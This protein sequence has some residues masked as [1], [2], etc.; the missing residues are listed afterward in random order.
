MVVFHPA[1]V[2][3]PNIEKGG[4]EH[5]LVDKRSCER[6]CSVAYSRRA[7]RRKE[8]TSVRVGAKFSQWSWHVG[9]LAREQFLS[10]NGRRKLHAFERP[11]LRKLASGSGRA[12][13]PDIQFT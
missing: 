13:V 3:L 5:G 2:P 12:E 9:L 4:G 10:T 1:S 6:S 8:A 7:R 11:V